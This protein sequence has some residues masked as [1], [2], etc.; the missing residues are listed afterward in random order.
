MVGR[1]PNPEIAY[2]SL[3]TSLAWLLLMLLTYSLFYFSF[4]YEKARIS[5]D[6][7]A[8]IRFRAAII[9]ASLTLG[10]AN[11]FSPYYRK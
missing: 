4:G 8:I 1:L 9:L 5:G 10:F 3:V 7:N 2:F 11:Y 6:G